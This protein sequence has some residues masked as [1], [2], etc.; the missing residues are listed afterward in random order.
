MSNKQERDMDIINEFGATLRVYK[1]EP[2]DKGRCK[3]V[4]SDKS[5]RVK[6]AREFI[7]IYDFLNEHNI[8]YFIDGDDICLEH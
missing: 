6:S 1:M 4:K 3:F 2:F 8:K 5:D 7:K